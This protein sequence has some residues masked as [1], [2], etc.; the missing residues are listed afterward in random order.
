MLW[1]ERGVVSI[2]DLENTPFVYGMSDGYVGRHFWLIR[3]L[4]L[5]Y[6]EKNGASHPVVSKV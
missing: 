6:N 4:I 2:G 5:Y 1:I 3:L